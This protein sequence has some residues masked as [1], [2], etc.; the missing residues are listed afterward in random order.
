MRKN[1]QIKG[2]RLNN[3]EYKLTQYAD[4]TN[5]FTLFEANSLKS[6]IDMF[7]MLQKQTG[8]KVNYEKT[9]IYRIGSL[10]HSNAKLYTQKTFK[11]V[12]TPI[13]VLGT[14]ISND[15]RE[16]LELNY[17]E[18]LD[19][20]IKITEL[21]GNRDLSLLGKITVVNVLFSS[22]FVYK[23]SC[24]SSPS[25]KHC[26]QYD[27]L[28]KDF[29]WGERRAKISYDVLQTAKCD[30]GLKLCNIFKKDLSMKTQWIKRIAENES[31]SKLAYYFLPK[32]GDKIWECNIEDKDVSIVMP[33]PSFWRDVLTA[34]SKANY[35]YPS[36][37][38][39]AYNAV[40]WYNS[41]IKVNGKPI[42]Y[43]KCFDKGIVCIRDIL[44]KDNE[45]LTY[46]ALI[47]K[48]G[49]TVPFTKYYGIID[50]ICPFIKRLLKQNRN[51][52]K[53]SQ[54]NYRTF[55]TKELSSSFMYNKSIENPSVIVNVLEKWEKILQEPLDDEFVASIFKNIKVVTLSTKLRSFHFRLLHN[56]V[57][58]ND[59]LFKWK[60]LENDLC[61]FCGVA[62][63]SIIHLLWECDVAQQLWNQLSI[64]CKQKSNRNVKLSCKNIIFDRI[65]TKP[66][67]CINTMCL[68]TMHYIY[69]CRCLKTIPNFACLKSKI[70]DN[71]NIEKYIATKNDKLKKHE[72]KWKDF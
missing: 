70:L 54:S 20:I 6:I 27:K 61:T 35:S 60:I 17:N 16:V 52:N 11:W 3:Y 42:F 64:F 33:K 47:R 2:I 65:V 31:L 59:K 19:K 50:A 41:D 14:Y 46:E 67:D 30:G 15:P 72:T 29:I 49:N 51:S 39:Q 62:T 43:K 9:N 24:L 13:T 18:I 8:L 66:F 21:W 45:F 63:E 34:W 56:A 32:I 69:S 10:R 23:L 37:F 1:T 5:I 28:V 7:A 38:E 58:T 12:T 57:T 48:Y 53:N 22:Q 40:L 36:S 25:K 68:I 55:I 26:D 44:N 4:D 71:Q